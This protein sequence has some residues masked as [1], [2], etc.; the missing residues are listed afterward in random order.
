VQVVKWMYEGWST[1]SFSRIVPTIA[2][3]FSTHIT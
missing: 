1:S 3:F 2:G